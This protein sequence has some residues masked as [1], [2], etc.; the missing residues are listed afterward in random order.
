MI[1]IT[2]TGQ[3][4]DVRE[5][6]KSNGFWW[7][8]KTKEWQQTITEARLNGT[9]EDIR[10]P[11]SWSEQPSPRINV[12]LRHVDMNGRELSPEVLGI[13]LK[14]VGAREGVD[15]LEL[16]QSAVLGQVVTTPSPLKTEETKN[17]DEGFF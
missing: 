6:L 11:Q 13:K 10:P 2:V 7:N 17:V 3:T 15:F 5:C 14:P 9:L 16:F 12:M 4:Y 1:E 8:A